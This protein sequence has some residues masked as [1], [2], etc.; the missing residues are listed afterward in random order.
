MITGEKVIVMATREKDVGKVA[1][2]E[3]ETKIT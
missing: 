1:L 2:V 3:A